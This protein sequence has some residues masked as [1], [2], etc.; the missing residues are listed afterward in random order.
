MINKQD[1]ERE[2]T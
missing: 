1:N 2:R